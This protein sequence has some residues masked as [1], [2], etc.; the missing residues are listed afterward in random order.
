MWT[1]HGY[2]IKIPLNPTEA[3]VWAFWQALQVTLEVARSAAKSPVETHLHG[4]CPTVA[5]YSDCVPALED[6]QIG[7]YPGHKAVRGLITDIIATSHALKLL[8]VDVELRW[9]P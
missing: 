4:P 5:I 7:K 1:T 6:I 2:I 9:V 3:E 8:G